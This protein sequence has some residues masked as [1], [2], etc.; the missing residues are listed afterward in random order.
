MKRGDGRRDCGG[1]SGSR[2]GRCLRMRTIQR[3]RSASRN[4]IE[5]SAFVST[6]LRR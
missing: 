5:R 2:R 1:A 4:L 3:L 6:K